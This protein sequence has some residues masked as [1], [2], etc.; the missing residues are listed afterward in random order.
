MHKAFKYWLKIT[1]KQEKLLQS[2]LGECCWL[3]NVLLE[4]RILA[5]EELGYSLT[6]YQQQDMLPLL[7][8]ERLALHSVHSQVIQNVVHR[9]DGAFQGFFRRLRAGQT[10]GFPRFRGAHRYDSFTF[11][12]S[13][14]SVEGKVLKLSKIGAL[15]MVLHRPI[16]GK[17]KTCTIR[18][19]RAGKWSVSLSCEVEARPLP[20]NDKAIGIDVGLENFA[21]CS[22]GC[23]IANP[24]HLKKE[25]HALAKAHRKLSA[26][27]KGSQERA[28]RRII[29][30][31]VYQ[32]SRNRRADFCHKTARAIVDNYQYIC[33]EDL[34]I[35]DMVQGSFLAKNILDAS[36]NQ[37]N[38]YL[39]YKAEEAG[40]K[41]GLV[42]PAYTSQTCSQCGSKE[43][44]GLSMREHICKKCG[45][46][47]HRD[48][49]AS[50]NIL[51]LGLDGLG[52][53]SRSLRPQ[54]RE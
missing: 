41:V 33:V 24:R 34:S 26:A 40:R 13:G 36:W 37:F 54:A 43:V 27:P 50:Q 11:P 31:K 16:E 19:D 8:E 20:A 35:A 39:F 22:D 2:T 32:R 49:N 7:K 28:K 29:L 38:R 3:Y 25:A 5:Y 45:Y 1:K 10:P 17:I 9:I 12:Q 53:S 52:I 23:V 48:Y 6:Y 30:S 46:M 51:A 15:R 4:Q 42:D 14:F 47:A 18:R 21:T 44:K